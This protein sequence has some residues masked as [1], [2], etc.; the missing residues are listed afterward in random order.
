MNAGAE[1]LISS[2]S[3]TAYG[4]DLAAHAAPGS[5]DHVLISGS[6]YEKLIKALRLHD[7]TQ[8]VAARGSACGTSECSAIALPVAR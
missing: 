1:R 6:A 2:I 4:H 3:R 8:I 7:S 5:L